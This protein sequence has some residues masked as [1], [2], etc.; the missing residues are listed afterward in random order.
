M[1]EQSLHIKIDIDE[2]ADKLDSMREDDYV[3]AELKITSDGYDSE[4]EVVAVGIDEDERVSYG[5]IE[6]IGDSFI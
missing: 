4:M 6:G 2:L 1:I 3:S 5:K